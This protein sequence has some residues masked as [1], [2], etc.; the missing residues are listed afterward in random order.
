M[1]FA[2]LTGGDAVSGFSHPYWA[3]SADS[4]H[5][6]AVR[7][8]HKGEVRVWRSCGWMGVW[9]EMITIRR[10]R[11]T[12]QF[13]SVWWQSG[14]TTAPGILETFLTNCFFGRVFAN[15][16][17]CFSSKSRISAKSESHEYGRA[18]SSIIFYQSN[19]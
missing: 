19:Q 1:L 17:R 18:S 5:S 15:K 6:R 9:T 13:F 14:G 2:P 7:T 16:I 3:I 12:T 4:T 8:L 11:A 10:F